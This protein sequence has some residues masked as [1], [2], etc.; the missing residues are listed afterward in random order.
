LLDSTWVV[1][2]SRSGSTYELDALSAAILMAFE[3]GNVLDEDDLLRQVASDLD[4]A[5]L[6]VADL[7]FALQQFCQCGLLLPAGGHNL[8]HG[9]G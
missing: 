1:F 9:I 6:C 5:S 8:M 7:S 2:E 4:L 3:A